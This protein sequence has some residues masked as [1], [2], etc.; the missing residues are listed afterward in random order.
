MCQYN[1]VAINRWNVFGCRI[2]GY[3]LFCYET[4]E[5]VGMTES[6][7]I[8][9]LKAG[10]KVLG[11]ALDANN[12][13]I[14]D[15]A[16]HFQTNIMERKTIS[17][18]E[19]INGDVPVNTLYTLLS[20]KDDKYE[21]MNSRYARKTISKDE[22]IT[23]INLGLVQS[24]CKIENGELVVADVFKNNTSATVV[25]EAE[26]VEPQPVKEEKPAVEEKVGAD[27]KS[28]KSEPKPVDKKESTA[29]DK[30][31][32][33]PIIEIIKKAENKK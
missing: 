27:K 17:K 5:L 8:K 20:V 30:P 12:K 26:K 23:Y 1:Y 33:K 31:D 4:S 15:E 7:I 9:M 16:N 32:A 21:L 10:G 28:I 2:S 11:L 13:L 25:K 18:M 6:A 19:A 3:E 24:G 29:K 22:L 14:L